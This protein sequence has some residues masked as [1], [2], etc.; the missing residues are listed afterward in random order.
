M[1]SRRAAFSSQ[2]ALSNISRS[3][4]PILHIDSFHTSVTSFVVISSRF[5]YRGCTPTG[6]DTMLVT[7]RITWPPESRCDLITYA[8]INIDIALWSF[9][10]DHVGTTTLEVE[11]FNGTSRILCNLP[12]QLL[13]KNKTYR[14][15]IVQACFRIEFGVVTAF[16]DIHH[17]TITVSD[18]WGLINI[19]RFFSCYQRCV[20]FF[21]SGR[22]GIG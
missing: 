10:S 11:S 2:H 13:I 21:K 19:L 18:P 7:R 6:G 17:G 4:W 15:F 12:Q 5:S 20:A 14:R 22:W 8:K 3:S 1:Y 16:M 9:R